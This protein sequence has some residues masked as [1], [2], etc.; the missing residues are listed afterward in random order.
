[1]PQS[2]F[3]EADKILAVGDLHGN[4]AGFRRILLE[5]GIIDKRG[6]WRARDTHLVQLGDILGRG[7]EPGKIFKLLK[8]LE[9]EAPEFGSCVHVLLGNHEAMS[10]SGLTIY[11]TMEEFQ[12]LAGEDMLEDGSE[13]PRGS[14]PR[15]HR[16]AA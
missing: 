6:H 10:M 5:A 3:P 13:G 9:A 1:M 14:R 7:G 15:P 11:N 16:S 8:R 4:Y 12:D 2:V